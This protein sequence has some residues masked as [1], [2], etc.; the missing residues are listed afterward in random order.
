IRSARAYFLNTVME[1]DAVLT[2]YG[3]SDDAD[4]D[5]YDFGINEIDGMKVASPYIWRQNDLGKVAPHNAYSSSSAIR[6]GIVDFG[7]D[8]IEAKGIFE[9]NIEDTK[10]EAESANRLFLGFRPGGS[11]EF[12]YDEST[13]TYLRFVD[14]QAHLEEIDKTQIA[15]K[16]IIVQMVSMGF[17]ADGV[18]RSVDNVGEGRGYLLTNGT[19][20]EIIW[21]KADRSS[22]T[23]FLD[24]N[25]NPIKLNPGQTWVEVFD[26][27]KEM[28]IE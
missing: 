23:E 9:F 19:V 24:L 2:R 3:G 11:S 10:P 21:K 20:Q 22:K 6:Q 8:G 28:I 16:N 15:A 25:E 7:Y 1:Y 13:K 12:K 27:S 17:Y 5:V 26:Q 4:A 18:H 14:G